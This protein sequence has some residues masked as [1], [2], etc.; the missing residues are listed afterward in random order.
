M[1]KAADSYW[2]RSSMGEGNLEEEQNDLE[3]IRIYTYSV[4]DMVLIK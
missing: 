1:G 3:D 4:V 2:S